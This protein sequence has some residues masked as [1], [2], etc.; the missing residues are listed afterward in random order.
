MRWPKRPPGSGPG[1]RTHPVP[2]SPPRA[3]PWRSHSHPGQ[4]LTSLQP[5]ARRPAR[6]GRAQP[7]HCPT[8]G[9][10]WQDEAAPCAGTRDPPHPKTPLLSEAT[11]G[12]EPATL[13]LQLPPRTTGARRDAPITARRG[14]RRGE[15]GGGFE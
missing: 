9:G 2:P 3:L 12:L 4:L 8:G 6:R 7:S 13:Q 5:W 15:G 10:G 1:S 11:A 14:S